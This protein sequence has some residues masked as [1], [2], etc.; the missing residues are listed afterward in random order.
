MNEILNVLIVSLLVV[1][2]IVY[3]TFLKYFMINVKK[4]FQKKIFKIAKISDNLGNNSYKIVGA[5]IE[6]NFLELIK[7]KEFASI[8]VLYIFEEEVTEYGNCSWDNKEEAEKGLN[9]FRIAIGQLPY[10]KKIEII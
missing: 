4:N 10:E 7:L 2:G 5:T 1:L 6:G 9:D 3:F 8:K